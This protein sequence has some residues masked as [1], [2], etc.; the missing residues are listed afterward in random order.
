[1]ALGG[2][3]LNFSEGIAA[4]Y[5][6]VEARPKGVPMLQPV[7]QKA[8]ATQAELRDD[9]LLFRSGTVQVAVEVTPRTR[10]TP[11]GDM[12]LRGFIVNK[13]I[14]VVFPGRRQ[15]AV[16][17]LLHRLHGKLRRGKLDAPRKAPMS[18]TDAIRQRIQV[19]GAWRV[20]LLNQEDAS[21]ERRFQLVAARWRYRGDDGV[22]HVFGHLPS[23]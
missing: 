13:E 14:E 7:R 6:R 9:A 8:L 16:V 19:D 3:A 22:E 12:V 10:R 11:L 15:A 2:S 20:R 1:M 23:I 17:P 5:D 4:S 18:M 21:P